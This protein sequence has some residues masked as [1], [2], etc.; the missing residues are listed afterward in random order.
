MKITTW[1]VLRNGQIVP[2]DGTVFDEALSKAGRIIHEG[3][4][5]PTRTENLEMST[6]EGALPP[7]TGAQH[8]GEP[9]AEALEIAWGMITMKGQYEHSSTTKLRYAQALEAY[10]AREVA[11]ARPGI[12]AQ[13]MI[14]EANERRQ[15]DAIR[16][17]EIAEAVAAERER[18]LNAAIW[19]IRDV[20]LPIDD[21]AKNLRRREIVAQAVSAAIRALPDDGDSR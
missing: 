14:A 17:E 16:D 8:E 9:S 3:E 10:A 12:I 11:D 6:Q 13:R 15:D 20:G 18:C 2:S 5:V 21:P 1:E 4:I 19:A 7:A